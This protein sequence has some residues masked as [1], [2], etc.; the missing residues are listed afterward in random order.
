MEIPEKLKQKG[1]RFVLLEK[2]GK[3]PFQKDWQNK[4]IEFPFNV[5]DTFYSTHWFEYME[6]YKQMLLEYAQSNTSKL[7]ED[8]FLIVNLKA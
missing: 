4:N 2:S 5:F 8:R 7:V 3:K 6:E 1:I